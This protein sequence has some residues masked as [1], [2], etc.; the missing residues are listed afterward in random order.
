MFSLARKKGHI[1]I[2][3]VR[4]YLPLHKQQ[5]RAFFLNLQCR[6]QKNNSHEIRSCILEKQT[7][8]KTSPRVV[9]DYW[10]T[11]NASQNKYSFFLFSTETKSPG[12]YAMKLCTKLSTANMAYNTGAR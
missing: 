9:D 4:Q 1:T 7:T 3:K 10:T 12:V 8:T 5:E 11:G 6:E 2:A